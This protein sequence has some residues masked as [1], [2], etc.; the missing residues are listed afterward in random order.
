MYLERLE[1]LFSNIDWTPFEE[2]AN[3]LYKLKGRGRRPK[4]PIA[5]FKAVLVKMLPRNKQLLQ[6]CREAEEQP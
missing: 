2:N 3:S 1:E 6:A 5:Y 4:P